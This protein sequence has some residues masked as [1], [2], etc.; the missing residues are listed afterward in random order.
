MTKAARA[1]AVYAA[2][3][4]AT[5]AAGAAPWD[6]ALPLDADGFTLAIARRLNATHPVQ[7]AQIAA[8]L[9]LQIGISEQINL[10]GLF[11]ACRAQPPACLPNVNRFIDSIGG[12][13]AQ[14]EPS[15]PLKSAALR[16]ILRPRSEVLN[17]PQGEGAAVG[18]NVDGFPPDLSVLLMADTGGTPR[19]VRAADLAGLGLSPSQAYATALR[20]VNDTWRPAEV[21]F[22]RLPPRG[23][24]LVADSPYEA[25]RLLRADD[26]PA[27]AARF[28]NALIVATP[29]A[30]VVL[31]A[32]GSQPLAV[33]ALAAVARDQFARAERPLSPQVLKWTANGWTV[34]VQ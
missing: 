21:A 29:A 11:M 31:Y 18:M 20:N 24:G 23:I 30:G 12:A 3:L 27:I 5:G 7:P 1:L 26:W 8:P 13:L 32:D 17:D 33:S 2:T 28:G 4:L 19:P 10:T 6:M 16:V 14:S 15:A 25:S 34:V 9:T 22:A